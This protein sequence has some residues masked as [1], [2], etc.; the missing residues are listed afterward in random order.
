MIQRNFGGVVPGTGPLAPESEAV[1]AETRL[2]FDLAGSEY[3]ACHF[4]GGLTEALR[5]AQTANRYL[6]ERA[7]WKA[8]KED[9]DHAAETLATA[10]SVING[11]K[12]LLHPVLPHSTRLLHE[13]LAQ[14]GTV[15]DGGWKFAPVAAG[16]RLAP[17]RH[18]YRKLDPLPLA[19]GE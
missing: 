12:T 4:R 11:L 5:L 14:S 9:R 10:L 6:D 1:L 8:V 18:L 19:D 7:P 3:A 2:A 13:D 16:T 15:L 17:A